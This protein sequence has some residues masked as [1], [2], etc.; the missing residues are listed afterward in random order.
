MP[1]ITLEISSLEKEKKRE[2]IKG[3]TKTASQIT[4]IPERAFIVTIHENDWNVKQFLKGITY[5]LLVICL[6]NSN[7]EGLFVSFQCCTMTIFR[8]ARNE[9]YTLEPK[10]RILG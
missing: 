9:W 8:N 4:G 1:V 7:G 2:L 10:Q 6:F 3:F 5:M